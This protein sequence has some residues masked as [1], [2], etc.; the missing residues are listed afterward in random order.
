MEQSNNCPHLNFKA[1]VDVGRISKVDGGPI[2]AYQ[3]D[4]KIQCADCN[5]DFEFVGMPAGNSF[6]KPMTS[7]DFIEAR[8]PIR[9]FTNSVAS[10]AHFQ[11][12]IPDTAPKT[13]VS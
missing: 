2:E 13:E 6:E 7:M 4:I 9:P 12:R 5:M 1:Q 3:A 10:N 11:A 8:L